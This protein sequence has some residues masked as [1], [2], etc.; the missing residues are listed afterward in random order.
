QNDPLTATTYGTGQLIALAERDG[1]SAVI[2]GVGGSATV[3]GGRGALDALG[4][5]RPRIPVVV[6]CDVATGFLDAARVYGPQKG[7]GPEAVAHLE[8]RLQR[9]AVEL[10]ER[11]GVDVRE[12]SGSGAA[13][14]LAGGLA[15][16]GATLRPGFD[17][18]AEATGFEAELERAAAVV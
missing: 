13:G 9:F 18:V 16:I 4:W 10:R 3:D 7:A 15:A 11:T 14:G 5:R 6:A 2:V 8:E 17:V 1:A 12:L